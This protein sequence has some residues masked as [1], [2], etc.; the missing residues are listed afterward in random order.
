MPA[1]DVLPAP[2]WLDL[3]N[4]AMAVVIWLVQVI[5]YPSFAYLPVDRL[6]VWHARYT[7]AISFFVVPLMLGQLALLAPGVLR[8]EPAATAMA[9]LALLAW[10]VTFKFSVALHRRL[11]AGQD[12]LGAAALL[13][14]TNWPR[15]VLW[16]AVFVVGLATG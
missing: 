7:R 11:A 9:A 5:I 1:P 8:G 15:T 3:V 6:L 10:G 12:P 4:G 16:T 13:V 2:S 14:R